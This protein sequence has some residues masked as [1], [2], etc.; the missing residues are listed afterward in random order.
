MK[1]VVFCLPG[2]LFSYKFVLS[3]SNLLNSCVPT[4]NIIPLVRMAYS[5]NVYDVRDLCLEG[6][7][8]GPP[9]QKPFKG[10]LEYD[11]IM[12]ID[13]DI[14]FE[15]EQFKTLYDYMEENDNCHILSGLYLS[16]NDRM[17]AHFDPDLSKKYTFITTRDIQESLGSRP[18]KVLYSGMGFMLVRRGVFESIT[19]P[20]FAPSTYLGS[21][22]AELYAGEDASFCKRAKNAGFAT[23]LHPQVIVGHE[24]PTVLRP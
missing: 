10:Q 2:K 7:N 4:F 5:S 1:S 15:P 22:G 17:S 21:G 14:V 16:Q 9:N 6:N 8:N 24:K 11:Y 20:W 19:F 3:W 13:S 12:W 23:W 18:F